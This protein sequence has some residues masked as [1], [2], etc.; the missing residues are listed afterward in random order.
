MNKHLTVTNP[1]LEEAVRKTPFGMAHWAG[2]GPPNKACGQCVHLVDA[3]RSSPR[4]CAEYRRMTNRWG[5]VIARNTASC[6]YFKDKQPAEC[7]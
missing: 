3:N 1:A 4:R 5:G 7:L 6:K 2:T